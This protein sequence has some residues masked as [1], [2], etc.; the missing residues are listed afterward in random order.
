M[1]LTLNPFRRYIDLKTSEGLKIFNSALH[2]FESPL[3]ENAKIGLVPQDFQKLSDHLNR[4]GNQ[5]AFDYLFK[6]AATTRTIVPAIPAI[7]AIAAIPADPLAVPPILAQPR[8]LGVPGVPE[9]I[10]YGG[11]RNMLENYSSDNLNIALIN[12]S[13]IWGDESF[14]VQMPQEIR[15]MTIANGLAMTPTNL[16]PSPMGEVLQLQRM[17][18]KFMA[19]QLMSLLNPTARQTVEQLKKLYTWVTPD[20]KEEE[21]DGLTILAIILNRIRPHYKV[22]MYLEID[23]LKKETLEQHGNQIDL[24]FDSVRLHMLGIMQKNP[25]AYTDDQF[26]R[27]I[28]KELKGEQLPSAFRLEFERAEVKWLMNR[29]NYTSESLMAEASLFSLNLKSSGGWKIE[30]NKHQQIIALTTQLHEMENKLAELTPKVGGP[31]FPKTIVT[32]GDNSEMKGT[33]PL[34]RLKKVH[35]SEEH[36]MVERDGAKYYWCE[37]GHSFENKPCGMYCIHKPGAGHVAWLARKERFKQ[38]N[39]AKKKGNTI[40]AP[41]VALPASNVVIKSNI[42]EKSK[43]SLSKSLQSALMTTAGISE[44]Q[45]K[46]IWADACASSGN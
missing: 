22:D 14:T 30:T 24:Y 2:G 33:F 18:S 41:P 32:T 46:K 42:G 28:F 6:R 35:S 8:V 31:S 45:F 43:L 20:G 17:H 39:A 34:W 40:P 15:Q 26:V 16:K 21:M 25:A 1:A 12:A 36:C 9:I 3:V 44:D 29:E 4:L 37:D 27:D 19:H 5:F 7:A 38:E 11:Y 10:L 23:K 13:V